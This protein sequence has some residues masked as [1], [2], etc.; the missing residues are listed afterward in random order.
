MAFAFFAYAAAICPD[1][2]Y[3]LPDDSCV[4]CLENSY[5]QGGV[6]IACPNNSTSAA[7]SQ[8]VLQ[9]NCDDGF[10]RDAL[11][12]CPICPGGF[13]CSGNLKTACA[14]GSYSGDG[15]GL[16]TLCDIGTYEP[17]T[18]ASQCQTCPAGVEVYQTA[19]GT[20][21]DAVTSRANVDP[22][23]NKLYIFRNYLTVSQGHNLTKWSFYATKAGCAVTPAIFRADANG[24]NLDGN[25]WFTLHQAGTKR[26]TIASG[27][28]TFDFI[29]GDSYAVRNAVPVPGEPYVNSYEF[30]GWIFDGDVC[31]PYDYGDP[32]T[33]NFFVM[34]FDYDSQ[35]NSYFK[36][37]N[38]YSQTQYWSIQ[39]TY[40][41]G[42]MIPSTAG[43]GS[44][45][46]SQCRCPSG[47]RQISDGSCQ[48]FCPDG[49]YMVHE[50]DSVCTTCVQGHYCSQSVMTSCPTGQSAPPGSAVCF[51]CPGPGTHTDIA[52]NLCG[53]LTCPSGVPQRLGTSNWFGLGQVVSTVGGAGGAP[54]T[55]WFS[56]S[57]VIGLLLN[58]ASDRPYAMAQRGIDVT[59]NS[60]IA[61]QFRVVCTGA[62]CAAAFNVQ[63]SANSVDYTPIFTASSVNTGSW[64]Q[65]STQF[66]TPNSTHITLRFSAQMVP[67][68]SI[69]WI[70][71]VEVVTPGQWTYDDISRV[72]LMN[73]VNIQVPHATYYSE[74]VEESTLQL[75]A[76]QFS[77]VIS[78]GLVYTGGYDYV[79]SVWAI[80]SANLTIQTANGASQT[81]AVTSPSV[82]QQLV[83]TSTAVPTTFTLQSDGVVT[84]S[85]LSL[86]L[87]SAI[88]GCQTCLS[89]YWCRN[90]HIYACPE[91]SHSDPGSTLQSDCWCDPGYYGLVGYPTGWTPCSICD[92]NHYCL[93]GNQLEVCPNGTKSGAGVTVCTPCAEN[94]I[95]HGGQVGSC[96][97]HSHSLSGSDGIE[98]CI[99]D[100]GYFGIAPNC[101]R[102]QP[103]SYCQNGSA[104]A[105]TPHATSSI[106]S[107]VPESC[108]CDRGYYGVANAPCTACEEGSWCWTGI[109]NDCPANMWS[110]VTSSY[111]SNCTCEYGYQRSGEASCIP[112]GT[113][114]Y[115]PSRG[116]NVC[117]QCPAGTSSS[118][119][120]ATSSATCSL[121]DVGKFTDVPGQ[122]QCQNCAA[123]Y[124]QPYLGTTG[125]I[126]CWAGAY[127]L[128]GAPHCTPCSAGSMSS[129][130]A[131]P[132]SAVCS[133]CPVGSWSPGNASSC[134]IC[135]ACSFWNYPRT[136]FF[137]VLSLTHILSNP[138]AIS[139]RFVKYNNR[140]IMS[141]FKTLQYV[142]IAT[143]AYQE[144]VTLQ[145]P[146][147]GGTYASLAPSA[148]GNFVYVVQGSY[149]YRVDMDMGSWDTVYPS[150]LA[151]CVLE[152]SLL[153]WI[154]QA[155][156]IR[157]LDPV[158]TAMAKTFPIIGSSYI[159]THTTYP[160]H[161][162]V[163]GT[164]GLKKV[165]KATGAATLLDSSQGPYTHCKFTPDGNFIILAQTTAKQAWSYSLFDNRMTKIL[166]N[167]IV[168]DVV[169]DATGMTFAVQDVGVSRVGYDIKDSFTCS[170]GKFSSYSGLQLESQCTVC[171]A[172]SLCPGGANITQCAP[173]T[174]SLVT[175][176]REQA[177]CIICP[178]GSYCTGGDAITTCPLGT[179]QPNP[180]V[181]SLGGCP[182]C[183]AGYYCLNTTSQVVCPPNTLSAA[184]ADDLGKCICNAGY[185]C[186]VVKVVH[187]EIVLP[188]TAAQFDAEMQARYIAALAL[189]AGVSINDIHVVSVQSV[190]LNNGRRLM[191]W[192]QEGI[193]VHTSIYQ[194]KHDDIA[195]LNAHLLSHGLPTHRGIRIKIHSEIV[196][197]I[198]I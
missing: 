186:V 39:I 92:V 115:K 123:G 5:C 145:A 91:H 84:V 173:G 131:A 34:P 181:A 122:F 143:G 196:H 12:Q 16:C 90:Q 86:T 146:W 47:Y 7:A 140:Y 98:D 77:E 114:T 179:Y 111:A 137:Y 9:C 112:C 141:D 52:L 135:G 68:S 108:Y 127:S 2:Q 28:Q 44:S 194:S 4:D 45:A 184:G 11:Y 97:V 164:F 61:F 66:I 93:G 105:C 156:G 197:A 170:P 82:W 195:D 96:P 36:D 46:I 59:P 67:L 94:E 13:H 64:I 50:T 193:E 182:E 70:S 19:T 149:V 10:Y 55:P 100:D 78:P 169:T 14:A 144:V 148:L 8:S 130:V 40:Q 81:F 31:I 60:P 166:N 155:D 110:P 167:A 89:K 54:S 88:I 106:G 160:D 176:N 83:F 192:G 87:R 138:Q 120:G 174:Y 154:A 56:G 72:R 171:P 49:K 51:P 95:C 152:D 117:T 22:V 134:N 33:T 104:V 17:V 172:G 139:G 43:T 79:A 3:A 168:T 161:L 103:G 157:A 128:S 65:T 136:Q 26:V 102:C 109:K 133:A 6:S 159:C 147:V 162:F 37:G 183:L 20:E 85:G 30:F 107:P 62:S 178:P 151:T 185:K 48:A 23:A 190:S 116:E 119:T 57:R 150:S 29:Q 32:Q 15:Q 58:S 53:L 158:S 188:M 101:Q 125:C 189:A 42:N 113:G 75:A 118:A 24:G 21:F 142:D 129:V 1:G 187:A 198:K 177:Q 124:Y 74:L 163:A 175:G 18:G 121:C 76:A 71:A 99:C 180:G 63:W 41:W 165:S 38:V 27:A 73:T 126:A 80:G 69:V 132:S 153:V 25:I 35:V 191:E